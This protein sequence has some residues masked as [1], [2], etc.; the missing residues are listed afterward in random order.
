MNFHFLITLLFLSGFAQAQDDDSWWFDVE[1]ILFDRA[2][3]LTELDEQFDFADNL[4]PIDTEI[5]VISDLIHPDI[6]NV[7]QSL[8]VCGKYSELH[9]AT[10]P[11]ID[12]IL[13]MHD[14]WKRLQAEP[15]EGDEVMSAES[16]QNY[17]RESTTDSF[18]AS[19]FSPQHTLAASKPSS[20]DA[21]L[22]DT[23]TE[24]D[25][26]GIW[27]NYALPPVPPSPSI[28]KLQFCREEKAW[29]SWKDGTWTRHRE[30]NSLPYPDEIKIELNGDEKPFA[31]NAHILPESA[32]ELAKL[33]Q[34][35]RQARGLNRLLHMTWRQQV[36]FGKDNAEKVRLF[37]GNDYAK[38][39]TLTGDAINDDS[40]KSIIGTT[41]QQEDKQGKF[42]QQLQRQL[43]HPEPVPFA[44]M[45]AA[46]KDNERKAKQGISADSTQGPIPIWK[47]DGYMKVFLKYINRVP[48]LH[49]ESELFYRQPIPINSAQQEQQ[50]PQY[51]LVSVPFQQMRRVIS[52]QIHYFDH[53]LFGMVVQIRRHQLPMDK[54]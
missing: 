26:I 48:Y 51:R 7:K 53:P 2:I 46:V 47:L 50:N 13:Q 32:R 25:V 24:Q 45:M 17:E 44:S 27:L 38:Q 41:T 4:R 12:T 31:R 29:L 36:K 30:D 20:R 8:P 14:E 34:Q 11:S 18:A 22:A 54:E 1:V 9:L 15:L 35:I 21:I 33:S 3:A 49:I 28:P 5:D 19:R 42:F 16:R 37:A 40:I 23:V 39:F 43:N 10:P 52:K 6:N